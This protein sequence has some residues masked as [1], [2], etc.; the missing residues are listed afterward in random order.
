MRNLCTYVC[1]W[2]SYSTEIEGPFHYEAMVLIFFVGVWIEV[3]C[4][5]FSLSLQAYRHT[6]CLDTH[7]HTHISTHTHTHRLM[8]QV[9]ASLGNMARPMDDVIRKRLAG[10]CFHMWSLFCLPAATKTTSESSL[11]QHSVSTYAPSSSLPPSPPL[12][13]LPTHLFLPL[14]PHQFFLSPCLPSNM[15]PSPSFQ[16]FFSLIA[17]SVVMPLFFF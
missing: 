6:E 5:C 7:T 15:I 11:F 4:L 13:C 1:V 9:S 10:D 12:C 16:V 3:L 8:H 2:C 17:L 14:P